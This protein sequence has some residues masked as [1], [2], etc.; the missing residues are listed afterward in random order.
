MLTAATDSDGRPLD[1]SCTYRVGSATP[2]AR[3]WTLTL[4]DRAGGLVATEL[5]R[6]GFTSSEVLR[7][8]D[9]GYWLSRPAD[10]ITVADV[11]R[12]VEGPLASVRGGPPEEVDYRGAA[13]PLQQVWIAVRASLRGVV[14][15]VTLADVAAGRL[16]ARVT[17][18][19]E[20]PEAWVTR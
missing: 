17:K 11:I 12:A 14:E 18:L 16:P 15:R 13:E 4:Y 20:D 8:A 5:Q 9:G 2:Q 1:A 19:A 6:S 10:E 3:L 7:G